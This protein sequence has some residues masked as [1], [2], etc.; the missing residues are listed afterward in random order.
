M[1]KT[2]CLFLVLG[3]ILPFLPGKALGETLSAVPLDA[4][5]ITA[6]SAD[7][8][9]GNPQA[10]FE[11]GYK[12]GPGD[13]L[14][15]HMIVGENALVLDYSFVINP[16][17]KIFF[18]NIAEISLSGLTLKQAKEKLA[19]AIRNKY[20]EKFS[21]SLM[22]SIPKKINVYVTGQITNPGLKTVFD[23]TKIAEILKAVGVA[24]GGSDLSETVYVKRKTE[25][26]DFD[27]LKVK[28]YDVFAGNDAK[29]NITLKSGDIIAVP[30]IKSY[31]YVYGEVARG[32]T[33]GYVP[34]QS[35][36]DYIN[37]A[38]GPTA[39]ASLGGVTV[40]RQ[41]NGKPKV[42]HINAADIIQQG[43]T[44]KDIEIYAGDV[45]NV[46]GNFFYFS[47]FSS[48]ANTIL[49]ALTLYSTV[50]RK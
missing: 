15:A 26:G 38:G 8:S 10:I 25:K 40:T 46:P 20:E 43:M 9:E 22:V 5:S 34:G 29:S 48:F 3:L 50:A 33:F 31:V 36:S 37:I 45:I 41:E 27:D 44:S 49:L 21:L 4:G 32:G 11:D 6:N 16:E 7:A 42:Y 19:S 28:L 2:I 30:A 14:E 24:K 39:R 18:P 13:R 47:D 12:L 35:L 17:G 23:G 1:K